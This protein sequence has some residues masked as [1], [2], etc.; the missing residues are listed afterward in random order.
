MPAR[1]KLLC[2]LAML[3]LLAACG[4]SEEA[5]AP[6]I[7]PVRVLTIEKREGGDTVSLTG[8]VQA[9]TEVNLAFRIDGRMI[10]RLA[11]VGDP[12]APGQL[13]ARLDPENEENALRAAR[14]DVAGAA[15][16]L[17]E[18]RNNYERQ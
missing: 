14:A 3:T 9:Q 18:A 5:A 8:T 13:V 16:R 17:V 4:P 12:V 11:N 1:A 10:E 7:R 15:G 6:E 2:A